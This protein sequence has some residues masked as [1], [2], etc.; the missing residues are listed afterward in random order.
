M[1]L[2]ARSKGINHRNLV[3]LVLAFSCAILSSCGDTVSKSNNNAS[4]DSEESYSNQETLTE[5]QAI[6]LL[7]NENE[8]QKFVNL[9]RFSSTSYSSEV[10]TEVPF[11]VSGDDDFDSKPYSCLPVPLVVFYGK[12]ADVKG[13]IIEGKI[14]KIFS[15]AF[16]KTGKEI[17]LIN[18]IKPRNASAK[19]VFDSYQTDISECARFAWSFAR[20][21]SE[22]YSDNVFPR[23]MQDAKST[24]RQSTENSF[25]GDLKSEVIYPGDNCP[26]FKCFADWNS[27]FIF[28]QIPGYILMGTLLNTTGPNERRKA[29]DVSPDD[30]RDLTKILE[31]L[32]SKI[33]TR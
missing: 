13:S 18:I 11:T 30:V 23:L 24:I 27:T 17:L 32:E 21:Y 1:G 3:I 25:T 28:R 31:D 9:A 6:N 14:E 7:P 4:D 2:F 10:D 16:R 8:L 12:A 19:D 5:R 20:G 15:V 26:D 33:L 29:P 22:G